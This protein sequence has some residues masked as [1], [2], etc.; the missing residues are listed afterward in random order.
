MTDYENGNIIEFLCGE[1]PFDGVWFSQRHQTEKGEFWWRKHLREYVALRYS[2]LSAVPS[3][4]IE[5]AAREYY[6]NEIQADCD[7][8][9]KLDYDDIIEAF[10]SGVEWKTQRGIDG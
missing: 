1:K 6:A 10:C 2:Q 3:E 9:Q 5:D 4:E 8:P 7:R